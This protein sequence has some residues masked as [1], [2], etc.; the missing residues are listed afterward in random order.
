MKDYII[1]LLTA[2]TGLSSKIL[3]GV[4]AWIICLLVLLYCTLANTQAPYFAE[5]VVITASALL[6]VDSVTKI[7]RK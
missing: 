2:G 7:W 3:V 4:V 1:K 5:I 6:G